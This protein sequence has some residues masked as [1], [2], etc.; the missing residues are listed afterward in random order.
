VAL[1]KHAFC[2]LVGFS[3]EQIDLINLKRGKKK[4]KLIKTRVR[5]VL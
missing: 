4:K 5:K 2:S 1:S 3:H